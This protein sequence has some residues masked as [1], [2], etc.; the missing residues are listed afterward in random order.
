MRDLRS[1]LSDLLRGSWLRQGTWTILDQGLFA[2]ANFVVNVLL[3]RWLTPEEFGAFTVA[4]VVFLLAGTVHGGLLIEPMLVF[5]SGRF[6][7]RTSA[8][9]RALLRAHAAF[10]AVAGAALAAVGAVAWAVWGPALGALFLTLA[11][12]Q[13][14]VL[15]QWLLRRACYVVSR[16]DWAAWTGALYLALLVGGAVAAYHVGALTGPL[17][18]GL[19]G[20]ASLVAAAVLAVRL[21]VHRA[22]RDRR[23][24]VEARAVHVEYGRWA[25]STGVLEWGQVA[26]PVLALPLFVGLEG[27]GTLRALSNLALPA[28]QGFAALATLCVPAFVRARYGGTFRQTFRQVAGGFAGLAVVYGGLV[29]VLGGPVVEWLYG[30]TYVATPGMLVC[31]ALLPVVVA[32]ANV[33]T[34]AVRSAERPSIVFRARSAAVGFAATAGIALTAAFGVVGALAGE[35]AAH[36]GEIAVLFRPARASGDGPPAGLDAPGGDGL[37]AGPEGLEALVEAPPP[38]PEP[39]PS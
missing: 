18:L 3:A 4:F 26:V 28:I 33:L 17:A 27:A 5:G 10:A 29:L 19:M 15:M 39:L 9:L 22:P 13:G 23:L 34:A 38:R 11:V 36:V 2:G 8:Y 37:E 31:L 14:A 16:P 25:A 24:A 32:L 12:V 21:G 30:G 35:V 1:R 20:A 7:G 6:E